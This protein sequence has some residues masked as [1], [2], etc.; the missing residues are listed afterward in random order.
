MLQ[1]WINYQFG[2][3]KNYFNTLRA[4][5]NGINNILNSYSHVLYSLAKCN[6]SKAFFTPKQH[7][8]FYDL[9]YYVNG[10]RESYTHYAN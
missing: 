1:P 10:G 8:D 6:A 9:D 7:Y 5:R 4:W 2:I 3:Q